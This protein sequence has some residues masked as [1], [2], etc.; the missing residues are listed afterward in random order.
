MAR[1][2]LGSARRCPSLHSPALWR[3]FIFL[4]PHRSTRKLRSHR[5]Q[6]H[7]VAMS[8]AIVRARVIYP[9]EDVREGRVVDAAVCDDQDSVVRTPLGSQGFEP[10][11][12]PRNDVRGLSPWETRA[13]MARTPLLDDPLPLRQ[14]SAESVPSHWPTSNSR[15]ASTIEAQSRRAQAQSLQSAE[16][17]L[18][19]CR[20]C[21]LALP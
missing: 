21:G 18:P 5:L 17:G 13:S 9:R 14:P 4:S 16:R 15:N 19:G 20:K 1:H 11:A 8:E 2:L 7:R 3:Q 6:Q 10:G 12:H